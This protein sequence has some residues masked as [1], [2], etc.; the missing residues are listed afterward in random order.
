[1]EALFSLPISEE[2]IADVNRWRVNTITPLTAG[3]MVKTHHY[4]H[5]VPPISYAFGL[6]IDGDV[7]GVATFGTPPSRHLQ[8]SICPSN[9]D[10]VL[11]LN[12][13][14]VDDIMPHNTESWFIARCL[15]LLPA[16]IVVSYA[17]TAYNHIGYI[18]RAANFH[19]AGWT[20]MDR[21][22]PRFDYVVPGK[23][24]RD[25]MR[26]GFTE[27]RRRQPKMK[28]WTVTGDKRERRNL[29]QLVAWPSINWRIQ[30]DT[31]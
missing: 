14:W 16:S 5:R 17:D 3:V 6:L 7:A 25:A 18:Y 23:H 15:K 1:M 30:N 24:S 8:M 12:R 26:H 13:L 22:T 21:K 2:G 10:Y 19:F 9:P 27:R 29:E 31:V 11:E 4:L 20:D 28:Y